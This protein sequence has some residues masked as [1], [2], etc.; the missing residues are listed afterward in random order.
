M[1]RYFFDIYDGAALPD[2]VGKEFDSLR[3]AQD[4]AARIAANFLHDAPNRLWRDGDWTVWVRDEAGLQL[5]SV[6]L[7]GM[8]A[9]AARDTRAAIPRDRHDG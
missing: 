4:E 7:L 6:V 8:L 1:S 3:G 9:P 2:Q 5:F